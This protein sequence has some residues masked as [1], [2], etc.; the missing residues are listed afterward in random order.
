M[1]HEV[2]ISYSTRDKAVADRVCASL[3]TSGISCWIA[4][5]NILG[6]Q[7]FGAAIT[8]AI[9]G[10]RIVV[11]IFSSSANAS[12]QIG[13]EVKLAVD[14]DKTVIPVRLDP[15]P[16][17]DNFAYFLGASQWLDASDGL[18]EEHLERLG[19]TLRSY[20]NEADAPAAVA[21][22]PESKAS[23]PLERKAGVKQP[24]EAGWLR[25][26]G[27]YVGLALAVLAGIV[28]LR[29][30]ITA[31]ATGKV[32]VNPD[33]GQRYVYIPPGSFEMGCSNG[34][35]YCYPFE[36]PAHEV[37]LTK[38]FWMQ[39]VEVTVGSYRRFS[40]RA[41]RP[42][43]AAPKF[44]QADDHPV[45]NVSWNDADTYCKGAG[46]RLPTEA[47][48]EYAARAGTTLPQ[49]GELDEIAWYGHNSKGGTH[50]GGK[51][52]PN[53]WGLYD[54]LGNAWEWCADWYGDYSANPSTDPQ[55][56][57]NGSLRIVRGAAWDSEVWN[58]RAS[59]RGATRP[60]DQQ[61]VIGFRCVRDVMP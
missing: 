16:I 59:D 7:D 43:P 1:A 61:F 3:E 46:G 29:I 58:T 57:P 9:Q 21:L 36:I 55:G 30:R 25:R 10:S 49:Y 50:P 34:D 23:V 17:A 40:E 44:V 26:Y 32:K 5:R 47:E 48:W 54:M 45:V 13:R 53:R 14:N 20:L 39:E 22:G 42:V 38:G 37:H 24:R 51:K 33:D 12:K 11:L 31:S 60:D 18:R 56:P 6:G 8:E 4:P 52:K 28:M 35:S 15:T 19:K 27:L 41:G 2:F